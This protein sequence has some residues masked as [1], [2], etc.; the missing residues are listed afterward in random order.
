M[1]LLPQ[2]RDP[3]EDQ[4]NVPQT[5]PSPG[6]RSLTFMRPIASGRGRT[7]GWGELLYGWNT[8]ELG[9]YDSNVQIF[10]SASEELG[11]PLVTEATPTSGRVQI[12]VDPNSALNF[13]MGRA[14]HGLRVEVRHIQAPPRMPLTFGAFLLHSPQRTGIASDA[15]QLYEVSIIPLIP[16]VEI[17]GAYYE[18]DA[19]TEGE[20]TTGVMCHRVPE[21]T[22]RD[23]FPGSVQLTFS[24]GRMR[25]SLSSGNY[26]LATGQSVQ[27]VVYS[28]QNA[29][30]LTAIDSDAS[31]GAVGTLSINDTAIGPALDKSD[32]AFY[33]ALWNA[34]SGLG[35]FR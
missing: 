13:A 6:S 27:G 8:I 15:G 17:G 18:S 1:P 26:A 33:I 35:A 20:E 25:T 22:P 16:P 23:G 11:V 21:V 9:G 5:T 2:Y 10:K 29:Y 14:H 24:E 31:R 3:Y 28:P 32:A 30:A 12:A 34:P 19:W 7:A 4:L